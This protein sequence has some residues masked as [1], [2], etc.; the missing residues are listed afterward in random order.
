MPRKATDVKAPAHQRFVLWLG[1]LF[2][3]GLM[4]WIAIEFGNYIKGELTANRL[5]MSS[6]PRA[7]DYTSGQENP[8]I[9]ATLEIKPSPAEGAELRAGGEKYR[10]VPRRYDSKRRMWIVTISCDETGGVRSETG[11]LKHEGLNR[12]WI[13]LQPDLAEL[14]ARLT[15]ARTAQSSPSLTFKSK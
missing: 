13:E 2:I 10:I 7:G 9:D 15:F 14:P 3:S 5:P 8:S 11:E 4:S 1:V 6:W 12:N